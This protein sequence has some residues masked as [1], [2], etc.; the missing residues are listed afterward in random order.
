METYKTHY[1]TRKGA[2]YLIID[3]APA[4]DK[5]KEQVRQSLYKQCRD[6]GE[7]VVVMYFD[8]VYPDHTITAGDIVFYIFC[9]IIFPP[10]IL[11]VIYSINKSKELQKKREEAIR[12]YDVKL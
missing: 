9:V 1:E 5:E 2:K 7:D 6:K 3:H 12:F 4:K 11:Y 10:M 8:E